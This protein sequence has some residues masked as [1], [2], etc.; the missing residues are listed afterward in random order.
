MLSLQ[1]SDDAVEIVGIYKGTRGHKRRKPQAAVYFTHT[2]DETHGNTAP[3]AG[4]LHLHRDAIKKELHINQ[5]EFTEICALLD[6]DEEPAADDPLKHAYWNVRERFER[7]LKREMFLG[8]TAEERFE[9]NFPR[10][11]ADWPGTMTCIGSSGSGKTH[12]V[13]NMILRYWRSVEVHSRRPVVWISPELTL[14]K[15]LKPLRDNHAFDMWFHGI[16]ISEKALREKGVDAAGYFKSVIEDKIESMSEDAIVVFDD[17]PDGARSLYTNLERLYNSMLRIARHRNMGVISLIHTYAHGK[18]SSQALQ[19][20]RS[21][22]FYPRS[23]QTR[24]IQ[25]LR[26]YLQLGSSEAKETVQRF[27][28]LGRWMCIRMHSPVCIF[29]EKYLVLL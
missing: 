15:T 10:K 29:N 1:K 8:D 26:D 18:A 17:F 23:Q 14:D 9:L 11:K 2:E 16:D 12:F 19:S 5:P 4:V 21:V 7:Y 27:A 3:A 20:N 6:A 25:F 13:V 22:I 28:K 24:C